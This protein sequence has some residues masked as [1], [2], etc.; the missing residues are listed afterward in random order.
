MDE[1]LPS[2]REW[3]RGVPEWCDHAG[4]LGSLGVDFVRFPGFS[5]FETKCSE[6]GS[7]AHTFHGVLNTADGRQIFRYPLP[8]P[9]DLHGRQFRGLQ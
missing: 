7:R 8:H 6:C 3:I 9:W 4:G 5:G 2:D 1:Q